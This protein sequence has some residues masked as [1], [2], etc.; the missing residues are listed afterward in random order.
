MPNKHRVFLPGQ[1]YHIGSRGNRKEPLFLDGEDYSK[2]LQLITEIY[3]QYPTIRLASYCIMTNH[4]HLQICSSEVSLSK[5]M[6]LLNKRYAYYFNKKYDQTG[7]VFEK[8]FFSKPVLGGAGLLKV[9][10]YIHFN[11]VNAFIVPKPQ[12]Y[13][14]SS[15]SAYYYSYTSYPFLNKEPIL[16]YFNNNPKTYHQWCITLESE[17]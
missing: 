4:Y 8:R 16:A 14:W 6:H 1:F 15:Y 11:P 13:Q 7:H 2:F 9:S 12:Q 3:E 5:V 17:K 10:H